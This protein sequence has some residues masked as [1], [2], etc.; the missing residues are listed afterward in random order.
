MCGNFA[1]VLLAFVEQGRNE[2]SLYGFLNAYV[3]V[4]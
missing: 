2:G 3:P 1:T 4:I